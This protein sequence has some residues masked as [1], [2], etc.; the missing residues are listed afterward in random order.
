[1][2]IL[3]QRNRLKVVREAPPGL[4]LDD[5]NLG[6]ILLPGRYIQPG[7]GPGSVLDVFVYL[8]SE[9]RRVATTETPHAMVGEF[10]CLR[11]VSMNRQIGAF[12]D[13]GLPKDLLLPFREQV[14]PDLHVGQ[15]VVV[16]VDLD[17][18]TSRLVA[19]MRLHRHLSRQKPAYAEGQEVAI[20]IT[21]Q[22]P[23]GYNA[24]VEN[25]HGGLLYHS[26]L[27]APLEI[28]RRLKAFVHRV[29]PDGKIDLK[30]DPSGHQR[31]LPLR[32]QILQVLERNH[33]RME[34]D[35]KSSPEAIRAAFNVSKNTFKL[36]LSALYKERRI[37]FQNGGTQL[38]EKG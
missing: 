4:Y 7:V 5:G 29:R 33:G 19:T 21:G 38:V 13:W 31:A 37:C 2:A 8:D 35:I 14:G 18:K 1:M 12:L 26:N 32:E 11:V 16:Y 17:T 23:L 20:L 6:E 9:D 22:T 34:F 36:A 24:I 25:A 15:R 3:G 10:A 27:A 28:G 30:L